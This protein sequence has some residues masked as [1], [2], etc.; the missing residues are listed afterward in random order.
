VRRTVVVVRAREGTRGDR[1]R[2]VVELDRCRAATASSICAEVACDGRWD[3]CRAVDAQG[4]A[5]MCRACA[6]TLMLVARPDLASYVEARLRAED[7][8]TTI[9]VELS[10][11]VYPGL[12]G[13][14]SHETIY[15]AV[16]AQGAR[17]LPE[18]M[19][20]G[21]RSQTHEATSA[22]SKATR[23]SPPARLV[24]SSP[25]PTG[26]AGTAGSQASPKTTGPKQPW[27]HC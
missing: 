9:A 27:E 17:G 6:K 19:P 10:Q 8:R 14:V 4:R 16:Y 23:S 2:R 3:A 1:T 15:K 24:R 5:D 21:L 12:D 22:V 13:A 18:G 7:S 11:G 25:C 20:V 26:P